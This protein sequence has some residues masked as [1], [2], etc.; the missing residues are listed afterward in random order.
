MHALFVHD[1][2]FRDRRMCKLS[3]ALKGARPC[4][5]LL[6]MI[7]CMEMLLRTDNGMLYSICCI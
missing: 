1:V 2:Q 5:L 7:V 3:S 4:V 6:S